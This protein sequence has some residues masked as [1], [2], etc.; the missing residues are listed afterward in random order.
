LV[1]F[2]SLYYQLVSRSLLVIAGEKTREKTLSFFRLT[3]RKVWITC[4][5][6]VVRNC[7]V[8]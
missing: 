3:V 7:P 2:L 6:A 1:V 4:G 5:L 8:L